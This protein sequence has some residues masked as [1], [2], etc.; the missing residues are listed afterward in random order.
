MV[1]RNVHGS[2][3]EWVTLERMRDLDSTASSA[4]IRYGIG[5]QWAGSH[6]DIGLESLVRQ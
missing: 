1:D 3:A 5:S 2:T 6:A 4:G